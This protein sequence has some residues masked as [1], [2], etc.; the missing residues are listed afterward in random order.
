MARIPTI[1]DRETLTPEHRPVW[2][3]I[4]ERRGPHIGPFALLLHSPPLADR[5]AALGAHIRFQSSLTPGDRELAILTV[6]RTL[7]CRFEWAAHL[8]LARQAGVREAAITVL[9]HG[10]DPEDLTGDEAVLVRYVRQ[11]LQA[12]RVDD[13]TFEALQAR[14]G[15]EPLVELTA[16]VG[17]YA[18]IACTLNA[19]AVDPPPA[20]EPLPEIQNR[21]GPS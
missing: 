5:T 4:T 12:H 10:Q 1:T 15:L 8:P 19:F 14:L 20:A 6:A 11:L 16:T 13:A 21:E 17:Y 18:M 2:D 9:R 7:D 3:R